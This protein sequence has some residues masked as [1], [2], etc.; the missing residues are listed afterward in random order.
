MMHFTPSTKRNLF[1]TVQ[2]MLLILLTTT[3][4]FGQNFTATTSTTWV[5]PAGVTS[6]TVQCWGGGGGVKMPNTSSGTAAGG[7]GGGGAAS[8]TTITVIP[9]QSYTVTVGS[10]G[11]A[12]TNAGAAGGNG[13]ITQ[14]VLTSGPTTVAS[15]AGGT[16]GGGKT[17]G[18]GTQGVGGAGGNAG[19]GTKFNG[20]K[21]ANGYVGSS[22]DVGGAGGG[23]AG[24]GGNGTNGPIGS[25]SGSATTGGAGGTGG[26]GKGGN[27]PASAGAAGAI[28]TTLG[29]GGSGG[30]A[31]NSSTGRAGGAGARGELRITYNCVASTAPT[32]ITGTTTICTGSTTLTSAGGSLGTDAI[33]IWYAGSCGSEAFTQNWLTQPYALST[34]TLNASPSYGV[35]SFTSTSADPNI[36]ITG[37]SINPSTHK[38]MNVRF[39]V[40]SVTQVGAMEFFWYN[41]AFPGA[42]GSQ[43]KNQA[44]TSVQNVWQTVSFDM[45][46]TSAGSWTG[47]TVTGFRFD[48]TTN[49]GVTMEIDFIS[50]TDVP[51]IGTGP[52]VSVSPTVSTTYYTAKKGACGLTACTSQAVTISCGTPSFTIPSTA[53]VGTTI[54]ITGGSNLSGATAVTVNGVA[55]SF[56]NNTTSAIDIVVPAGAVAGS[57]GTISI[58]T[59]GGTG[60]S[61]TNI[62]VNPLATAGTFQYTNGSTQS[63]CS[64]STISCSNTVAPTN[65]GAG[66]LSVVWYCG[67]EISPGVYGNWKESTLGNVSGTTSS[68]ALNAAA[69]GGTGMATSL[70]NYNPLSDFPSNTKFLVIRRGYTSNCGPCV[71]GCQD[72]SFYLN[73]LSPTVN[74]G[75]AV[76]A[77]CSG[78]TTAALGGSFG[79]SATGAVWSDGGAG[80]SFSN[81]GGTTPGTATYTASTVFAS[82]VTLTLTT[83]GGSCGTINA[84]K[85]LTINTP[86]PLPTPVTASPAAICLGSSTNLNATFAGNSINWYTTATGGTPFST[87][88]SGTNVSV[89][90]ATT[91]TYY[92]E[93]VNGSTVNQTFTASGS[94]T[95]PAGVTSITAYAW[96]GGGGGGGAWS[97]SLSYG[98]GGGGGGGSMKSGTLTVAPA[99]VYTVTIGAGGTAGSSSG[100][101][102]GTGGTT[103]F[104]GTGGTITTLGGSGGTGCTTSGGKAGGAGGTG[105]TFNG[106]AGASGNSGSNYEQGGGGGAGA[107][108]GAVGGNAPA[109][110]DASGGPG[111]TGGGGTYT[112]GNG[113]LHPQGVSNG[114][115]GGAGNA[116]GGGGSGASDYD[117]WGYAGGAGARGQVIIVANPT[118]CPSATRV[119]VVV[120]V[121]QPATVSNA[122][123]VSTP[124]CSNV[125]ATLSANNP[126]VGTG[127]WSVT[128]GPS[129]SSAQFS[130]VLSRTSTFTPAGGAGSYVLAWTITN[131]GCSS[132][133]TAT[134]NVVAIPNQPSVVIGSATPC[135]PS[136]QT[137]AVTNDANV[138]TYNWTFPSGW[139]TLSGGNTNSIK[140]YLQGAGGGTISVTGTNTCGTST[141]RTFAVTPD[142]NPPVLGGY[143]DINI[144]NISGTCGA[145]A[146]W[147]T[148]TVTDAC[149]TFGANTTTFSTPGA[150]G[151]VVPAGVTSITVQVWGAGGGGGG[152]S[153]FG[154]AGSGGG[155]GGG[156]AERTIAVTPGT[157]YPIT[158]GAGGA[159]GAAGVTG[160]AGGSSSFSTLAVATGGAGGIRSIASGSYGAGGAGGAGTVGTILRNGGAGGNAAAGFGGGGGGGSAGTG[161]N[162]NAGSGITGGVA[163]TDGGAGANA[164]AAISVNGSIGSNPGGGGSGARRGS[165]ILNPNVTGGAGGNGQVKVSWTQPG[166][167]QTAGPVSGSTFAV[168]TTPITYT[169]TDAAGFSSTCTF[170]VIVADAEAPIIATNADINVCSTTPSL[171]APAASDNCSGLGA[172]INNAPSIFPMG[173]TLVTWTVTDAA[174]NTS[175]STQNVTVNPRPTAVM[176][177]TANICTGYSTN[178]SIALTGTGPWSITYTDGVTPV[179][180]TATS[181]PKLISVSPTTTKTYTVSAV[182]DALCSSIPADL[183]GSATVTPGSTCT[184]TW[185]GT[186]SND[187]SNALNWTPNGLPNSCAS[188]VSIPSGTP[189]NPT[190]S[191]AISVGDMTIQN[192]AQLTLNSTLSI[193][194]TL[195]RR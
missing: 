53:C 91:T 174:N 81:N 36:N 145:T 173:T 49:N 189:N 157:F 65:G 123:T 50:L 57:P 63:I 62:T 194:G 171:T 34:T 127:Q 22:F 16:G 31:Y 154:Q 27:G 24:T 86:A 23:G 112:G 120:T 184:L 140:T 192:G 88:A 67:E 1:L 21:G 58:T 148:P 38:Y 125:A 30:V 144:D 101:N 122:G 89:S 47:S 179:T 147:S 83:S 107:G 60:T 17:A 103:T 94:F 69:G 165:S 131:G 164:S 102:G 8:T 19:T 176:S 32:S 172:V 37:L 178:L 10:G 132:N 163:V 97:N 190:I 85:S 139:S 2:V 78:Q 5:V 162:G 126:T 92:A 169:A 105:G 136:A 153:G 133:S 76:T 54:N 142:N 75:G 152:A 129:T 11:T 9:G 100:G 156:F 161:A 29:G 72:Q 12:G 13:G 28:G 138:V 108:S 40:T 114:N 141:A 135:N 61:S 155:G 170:N 191:S 44:V 93:S 168:G 182:S 124:T 74:V 33:D 134:A 181:S 35:Q 195:N 14:L 4:S 160:T 56:S 82:P 143:S 98:S 80:G 48:W 130:N 71:G 188:S 119:P 106:G 87:V 159:G 6:V 111:G 186:V 7:G 41:T 18:G 183:T 77:V 26:G 43:F 51:L 20:G 167:V 187:W 68:T 180:V 99:Q 64:G 73:V 45:S 79:G 149:T 104:S 175:T 84:S 3:V 158:V 137:Y 46:A 150:T 166:P 121:D 15:A 177:G 118:G 66:T 115:A 95:V 109:A 110:S 151:F 96:G 116:P 55:A 25:G 39:R 185:N 113:G 52:S 42:S 59:G 128:S 146:S 70:S 117:A 90:P 193:C